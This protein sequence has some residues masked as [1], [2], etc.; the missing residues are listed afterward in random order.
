MKQKIAKL[1]IKSIL[2]LPILF[3]LFVVVSC[4]IGG[5]HTHVFDQGVVTKEATCSEEGEL[6]FTCT[7]CDTTKT[8]IIAKLAHIYEEEGAITKN[9]TCIDAGV[10]EYQCKSCNVTK[11][12]TIEPTGVHTLSE[13][14][15]I[16]E[17]TCGNSGIKEVFC[18]YCDYSEE[19]T[20]E[21]TGDHD[22][23][24]GVITV[25][26]TCSAT[27]LME[28]ECDICGNIKEEVIE[29]DEDAHSFEDWYEVEE[30]TFEEEGIEQ[31]DCI[32]CD[33][34][35]TDPIEKLI[36]VYQIT[37]AVDDEYIIDVTEEGD[38]IVEDPEKIGYNFIKWIDKDGN[39]FKS[40]GV[41]SE[42]LTIYPVFELAETTTVDELEERAASGVDLIWITKDIVIDRT[43]YVPY[44]TTIY[45]DNEVKLIRDSDFAGDLFVIGVDKDG[46]D[47]LLSSGVVNLNFGTENK[48]SNITID[49]NSSNVKVSVVGSALFVTNSSIVNMYDGTLLVNHL[50][51]GNERISDYTDYLGESNYIGGA[52][53]IVANGTFNM[54]GGTMDNN[55]VNTTDLSNGESTNVNYFVSSYGGA[56]YNVW[57]RNYQLFG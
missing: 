1:G 25:S 3:L 35:E 53:V 43:I 10:I 13:E 36:S 32:Y 22:Y 16:K 39:E 19:V 51:V 49:G 47:Y 20:I 57:W 29:I 27:G 54:Y 45:A 52:A 5:K 34:F 55:H 30:P 14:K 28:Y 2:G 15:I 50:K 18:I 21:P 33:H 37:V 4:T 7:K 9:P 46:N 24:D 12:E 40:E 48:L 11:T 42:S 17:A 8:E 38:Y 44:S 31:R 41:I 6:T 26:P 56:V 23:L